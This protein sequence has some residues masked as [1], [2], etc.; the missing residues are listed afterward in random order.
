[1]VS[2]SGA[3]DSPAQRRREL[4]AAGMESRKDGESADASPAVDDGAIARFLDALRMGVDALKPRDSPEEAPPPSPPSPPPSPSRQALAS[5]AAE[6]PTAFRQLWGVAL[7]GTE[8]GSP[9]RLSSRDS[10][11]EE[12]QVDVFVDALDSRVGDAFSQLVSLFRSSSPP[13]SPPRTPPQLRP[14][15]PP[16]VS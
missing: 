12:D 13:G 11:E 9:T 16:A 6:P 5:A 7:G 2:P 8:P 3:P 15:G 14:R 4:V 1:M 10:A